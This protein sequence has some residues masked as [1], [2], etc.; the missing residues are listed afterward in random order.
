MRVVRKVK[1]LLIIWIPTQPRCA[2][3][4]R[5][6]L[7][8]QLPTPYKGRNRRGAERGKPWSRQYRKQLR[9]CLF[10]ANRHQ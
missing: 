6:T 2:A 5:S 9:V 10:A 8:E 7:R 1:K 4:H 3:R